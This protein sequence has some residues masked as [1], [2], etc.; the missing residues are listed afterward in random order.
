[1]RGKIARNAG[2]ALLPRPKQLPRSRGDKSTVKPST[3]EACNATL[4]SKEQ[5]LYI[6]ADTQSSIPPGN[7]ESL[8]EAHRV[9]D[10]IISR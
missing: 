3:S 4:I 7:R 6:R 8:S 2:N 9:E 1:M 10:G 5:D